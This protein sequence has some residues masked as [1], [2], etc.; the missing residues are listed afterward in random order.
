MKIRSVTF[1]R[2]QFGQGM[3]EYIIIVALVA[4]AG[5]AVWAAFGNVAEEQVASISLELSGKDGKGEITKAQA[6]AD[7]GVGKANATQDLS[8]YAQQK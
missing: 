4:I 8:N 3:T 7:K 1:K 6:A 5:I 2:R